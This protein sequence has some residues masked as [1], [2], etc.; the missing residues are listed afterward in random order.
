L[1][2]YREA[3]ERNLSGWDRGLRRGGLEVQRLVVGDSWVGEGCGILE[4][5]RDERKCEEASPD[6]GSLFQWFPIR[7]CDDAEKPVVPGDFGV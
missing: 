3:F 1:K 4:F 2:V 7:V 5:V 6:P